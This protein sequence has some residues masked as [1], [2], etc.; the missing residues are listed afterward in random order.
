MRVPVGSRTTL[1]VVGPLTHPPPCSPLH[2]VTTRA[3]HDLCGQCGATC[4]KSATA[5]LSGRP[6]KNKNILHTVD[7]TT[8]RSRSLP[9][10]PTPPTPR[11]PPT[12]TCHWLAGGCCGGG[13]FRCCAASTSANGP[14]NSWWRFMDDEP[15]RSSSSSR[16]SPAAGTA[17]HFDTVDDE[18]EAD[19]CGDDDAGAP[20]VDG[21]VVPGTNAAMWA[22]LSL[23]ADAAS[24]F[25]SGA[26]STC[27]DRGGRR[28][29]RGRH[30]RRSSW[31]CRV[32][33]TARVREP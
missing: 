18:D 8:S 20:V 22:N 21:G 14:V 12:R 29:T 33:V 27:Q 7:Y 16:G 17:R 5:P 3:Q 6:Y 9:R 32:S 30:S 1:A 2:D 24:R 15:A 26:N 19:G 25:F 13:A 28:H 23:R 4:A 11:H 31:R 10:P